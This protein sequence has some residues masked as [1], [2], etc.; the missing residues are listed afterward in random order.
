[1]FS[2]VFDA[3]SDEFEG[4]YF[5]TPG[6]ASEDTDKCGGVEIT[7]AASLCD[8]SESC[9]GFA[10]TD[11]RTGSA[12]YERDTIFS[13]HKLSVRFYSKESMALTK[14]FK[15]PEARSLRRHAVRRG[16]IL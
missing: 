9:T 4:R 1:M 11:R 10:I 16:Q 8:Q 14:G 7:T 2:A 13:A 15:K 6:C 5:Q 3:Q 12:S